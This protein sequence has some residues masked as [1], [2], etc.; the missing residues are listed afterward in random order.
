MISKFENFNKK[1]E[2]D[3]SIF[4]L[5]VERFDRRFNLEGNLIIGDGD[6]YEEEGDAEDEEKHNISL[7]IDCG[8]RIVYLGHIYRKD[9][10][11]LDY[12]LNKFIDT[13]Y[14]IEL[15]KSC[16]KYDCWENKEIDVCDVCAQTIFNHDLNQLSRECAICLDDECVAVHHKLSCSHSFH[17]KC[18]KQVQDKKCPLCRVKFHIE[19]IHYH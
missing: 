7:Y 4:L 3:N 17:L 1:M 13:I 5:Q 10:E 18:L 9:I 6:N 16:L 8:A 14:S 19:G 11:N 2:D 12:Y 15:C